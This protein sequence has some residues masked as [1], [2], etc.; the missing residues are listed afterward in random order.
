[1][2]GSTWTGG[3]TA[4]LAILDEPPFCWLADGNA[5]GCDVE[6]AHHALSAIG[7]TE[8][9]VEQVPFA[10]LIPGLLG[11]RWQMT[12][13]MFIT[14]ARRQLVRFS[15]PLWAVADGLV[16]RSDDA[17]RFTEY[18]DIGAHPQARLAVATGQV[19]AER[20]LA[21]GVP[22]DRLVAF[23]DQQQA[24]AAVRAGTV[25]AAA[26]TAIGNRAYLGRLG[27]AALA[28]VDLVIG[29]EVGVDPPL[30]GYGFHPDDALLADAVDQ[31]LA[32]YVGTPS[33]RRLMSSYGFTTSEIDAIDIP[34]RSR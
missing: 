21:A 15:R 11:R 9:I 31:A 2:S 3:N 27:D 29:P 7:V 12:T 25:D 32:G 13:G 26:S 23:A 24:V 18:S 1:M 22:A 34:Q 10:D 20:A 4:V 30:G 33:H 6:V 17:E 19:Q 14:S 8:V 5:M 28:A 16:V